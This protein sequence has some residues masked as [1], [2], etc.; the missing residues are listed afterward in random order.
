[1]IGPRAK[2]ARKDFRAAC[3]EKVVAL[4]FTGS[5]IWGFRGLEVLGGPKGDQK[6][7]KGARSPEVTRSVSRLFKHAFQSNK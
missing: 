5:R 7:G 6:G 2:R 3:S 1:M 4:G